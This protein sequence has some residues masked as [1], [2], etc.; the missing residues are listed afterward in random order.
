MLSLAFLR[1]RVRY[2]Q[3]PCLLFVFASTILDQ[4]FGMD[5]GMKPAMSDVRCYTRVRENTALNSDG[6]IVAVVEK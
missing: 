4:L 3:H 1:Q 5:V 6:S 2:R